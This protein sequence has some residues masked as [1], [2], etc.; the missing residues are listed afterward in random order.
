MSKLKKEFY[1]FCIF[2]VEMVCF[3]D[4]HDYNKIVKFQVENDKMIIKHFHDW[5]E[6]TRSR[7]SE[8]MKGDENPFIEKNNYA[9]VEC[10]DKKA[11]KIR[12]KKPTP[13]F[14]LI[15]I[16]PDS[17]YITCLSNIKYDNPYQLVI[18]NDI[19]NIIV[20]LH[21]TPTL[22]KLTL[23]EFEEFKKLFPDQ[24][25]LLNSMKRII[26]KKESIFINY[27]IPHK[28]GEDCWNYLY[29]KDSPFYLSGNISESVTNFVYWYKE[30]D[31]NIKFVYY[32]K[33][34]KAISLLDPVGKR[35]E[36]PIGE[37]E[38]EIGMPSGGLKKCKK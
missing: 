15:R 17:K 29:K 12:F 7:R 37:K 13:A 25:L 8:M 23:T 10:F 34:L 28:I 18:L 21:I 1:L 2:F 31:P 33:I 3:A 16:S 20:S 35:F 4:M 11:K 19:G 36:I 5:S 27:S 24:F 30:P 22:A 9:Y 32:N 38:M 6:S 26:L 14:T